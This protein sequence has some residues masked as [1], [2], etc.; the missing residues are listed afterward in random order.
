MQ[1]DSISL[2]ISDIF[3]ASSIYGTV[4][5]LSLQQ[6]E[7]HIIIDMTF[8]LLLKALQY[9]NRHFLLIFFTLVTLINFTE[10]CN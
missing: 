3:G 8:W 10:A 6:E 2:Q 1:L 5:L 9:R 7:T 4:S